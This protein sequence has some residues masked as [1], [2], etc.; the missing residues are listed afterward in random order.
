MM[1]PFT[2][3]LTLNFGKQDG[4][5][6]VAPILGELPRLPAPLGPALYPMF[7]YVEQRLTFPCPMFNCLLVM[8][9]R[10][11][12]VLCCNTYFPSAA[13]YLSRLGLPDRVSALG[14]V[15]AFLD[16]DGSEE[17]WRRYDKITAREVCA[18]SHHTLS[19]GI[20]SCHT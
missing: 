17:A 14:L 15:K 10:C 13:V 1:P 4:L 19:Y 11:A 6:V 5:S 18:A 8:H 16:F 9:G 12:A 20:M 7:R 2:I 3:T